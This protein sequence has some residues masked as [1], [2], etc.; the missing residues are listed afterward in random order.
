MN[1]NSGSKLFVTTIM[2][3]TDKS[4]SLFQKQ[5]VFSSLSDLRNLTTI[6]MGGKERTLIKFSCM[7]Y[8]AAAEDVGTQVNFL[9]SSK[10]FV[11]QPLREGLKKIIRFMQNLPPSLDVPPPHGKYFWLVWICDIFERT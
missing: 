6:R 4:L 1:A 8:E 5:A 7:D 11:Y 2:E 9:I 10:F 3:G